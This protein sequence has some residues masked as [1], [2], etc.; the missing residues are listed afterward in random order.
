MSEEYRPVGM[1]TGL[2]LAKKTLKYG[3][4]RSMWVLDMLRMNDFIQELNREGRKTNGTDQ[5]T[6]RHFGNTGNK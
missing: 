2:T 6:V 5:K 3:Q 4:N 1:N